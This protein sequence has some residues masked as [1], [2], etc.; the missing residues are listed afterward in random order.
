ML[1]LVIV[2][3]LRQIESIAQVVERVTFNHQVQ[4]SSPCGFIIIFTN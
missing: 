1:V 2:F 4:G 3:L